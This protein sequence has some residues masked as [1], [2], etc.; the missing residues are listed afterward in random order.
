MLGLLSCAMVQPEQPDVAQPY[1]LLMFPEAIR[2][3]ALDTHNIDPRIRIT[4]IRVSPGLHRLR[5]VY[6]GQSPQHAGQQADPFCLETQAGQQYLFETKT[7]G[8]SWRAWIEKQERIPG[9]CTTHTC[10]ATE[11]PP[12]PQLVTQNFMCKPANPEG[13]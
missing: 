11:P 10:P 5:L 3:V 8:I 4:A 13:N 12:L 6:A 1:A 7:L 2:L 9:Y